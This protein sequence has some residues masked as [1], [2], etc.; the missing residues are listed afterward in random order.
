MAGKVSLE[1]GLVDRDALHADSLE[2][3]V[4]LD[5]PVDHQERVAVRQDGHHAVDV[6]G[7]RRGGDRLGRHGEQ[8]AV[9]LGDGAGEFCVGPVPGL[10]GHDMAAQGPAGERE[11]AD[12]VEDLVTDELVGEA[13]RLLAQDGVAADHERI[14]KAPPLINP[15]SIRSFTSS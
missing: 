9:A 2:V 11:I 4:E 3:A 6:E 13:E 10:H 15:F 5:D 7:R 14:L 12:D 8:V 1:E